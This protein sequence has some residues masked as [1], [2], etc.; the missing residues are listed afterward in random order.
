MLALKHYKYLLTNPD[1]FEIFFP[2]L[3]YST[4]ESKQNDLIIITGK[5]GSGKTELAKF[6]AYL[7]N[8]VTPKNRVI[9]FSGIPNLYD[10]LKFAKK[11]I[12]KKL[13]KKK[14]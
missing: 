6:L 14:N 8:K 5:K 12:S 3:A 4:N 13:K 11:L 7:Y 2:G 1:V 10:D 9:I